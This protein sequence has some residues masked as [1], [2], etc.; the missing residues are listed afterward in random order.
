MLKSA[1]RTRQAVLPR[2]RGRG[3]RSGRDAGCGAGLAEKYK[4][5]VY[6]F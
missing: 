2:H 4:T 3:A 6:L 5:C 1:H